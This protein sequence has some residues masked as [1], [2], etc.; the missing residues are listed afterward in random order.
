VT[1]PDPA[2]VIF[3]LGGVLVELGPLSDLLGS[4]APPAETFWPE[5][6]HSATVRDFEGGLTDANTFAERMVSEFRLD[7]TADVLIDRFRAWPKGLFDGAAELL[8]ELRTNDQLLTG[9]LSNSNPVHWYEQVDAE[10]IRSLFDAPFLSFEMKL[11]KPD[12]AIYDFVTASL[13]LEPQQI[14]YFDD[15]QINVDGARAAGWQAE[16]THGPN[17][18]R[19]H[20][21]ERGLVS[22]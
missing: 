14:L 20:L 8:A 17:D 21:A 1:S 7:M 19:V 11:I 6:L 9:A 13:D 12:A 16:V 5:W 15:N 22:L 10:K 2:A 4:G 3:D 18:C